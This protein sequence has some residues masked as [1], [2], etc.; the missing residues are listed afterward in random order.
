M[1]IRVKNAFSVQMSSPNDIVRPIVMQKYDPP[2][3]C[4]CCFAR[5]SIEVIRERDD[6]YALCRFCKQCF[7]QYCQN[8][9]PLEEIFSE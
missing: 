6:H 4:R 2:P 7:L 8:G 1:H 3:H 5:A 9:K